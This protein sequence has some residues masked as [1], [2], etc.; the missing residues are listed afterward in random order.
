MTL[1]Q[2]FTTRNLALFT[3]LTEKEG[4]IRELAERTQSSPAKVLQ[5]IKIFKE[6]SLV[7]EEQR[8]NRRVIQL[9]TTHPLTRQI[10]TLIN[11]DRILS[12]KS[13]GAL[14]KTGDLHLYGSYAQ[15]TDD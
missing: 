5:A 9:N 1:A 2:L 4:S 7:T 15:G 12:A 14:K 13:F 10:R 6:R 11:I 8:K 3:A